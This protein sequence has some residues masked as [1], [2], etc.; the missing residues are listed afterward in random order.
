MIEP[1]NEHTDSGGGFIAP[2][3]PRRPEALPCF[4]E[5]TCPQKLE[6]SEMMADFA[7][8]LK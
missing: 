5:K 6:I 7:A 8:R 3:A 1:H 4:R 2:M